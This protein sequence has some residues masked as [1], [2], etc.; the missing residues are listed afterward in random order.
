MYWRR[1]FA[2]ESEAG[3]DE[4]R[5]RIAAQILRRRPWMRVCARRHLGEACEPVGRATRVHFCFIA[6]DVIIVLHVGC[7]RVI[8]KQ[9]RGSGS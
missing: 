1:M 8:Q 4:T 3:I 9:T 7:Y 2:H 6:V 5:E